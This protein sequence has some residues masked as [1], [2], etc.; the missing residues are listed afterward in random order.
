[1]APYI[2]TVPIHASQKVML[3]DVTGMTISLQIV[4]NPELEMAI[5][6]YGEQVEVLEPVSLRERIRERVQV[7]SEK[8]MLK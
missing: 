2:R 7:L 4:L 1:M 5:L 8:Y 6:Q 3:A